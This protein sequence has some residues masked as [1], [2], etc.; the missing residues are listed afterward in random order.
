MSYS[1]S[2]CIIYPLFQS[3]LCYLCS[4]DMHL[5]FCKALPDTAPWTEAK[6]KYSK[7]VGVFVFFRQCG[8]VTHEPLGQKLLRTLKKPRIFT[9]LLKTEDQLGLKYWFKYDYNNLCCMI[10]VFNTLSSVTMLIC[11]CLF[12]FF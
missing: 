10:L 8:V 3:V 9:H 6:R 2:I 1:H 4:E 5:R 12:L 7:G 11:S